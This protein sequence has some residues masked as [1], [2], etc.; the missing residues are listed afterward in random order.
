MKTTFTNN[1]SGEVLLQETKTI[2]VDQN[3]ISLYF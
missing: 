3:K 2:V 1:S